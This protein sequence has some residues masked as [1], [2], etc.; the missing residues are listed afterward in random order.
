MKNMYT[1]HA[2]AVEQGRRCA[3]E[4]LE[5]FSSGADLSVYAAV[6]EQCELPRLLRSSSELRQAYLLGFVDVLSRA[7][8]EK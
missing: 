6:I 3:L 8:H 7:Y 4:L 1:A 2:A 5:V